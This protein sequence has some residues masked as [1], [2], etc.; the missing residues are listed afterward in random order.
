MLFL[1]YEQSE[2]DNFAS[3]LTRTRHVHKLSP[4]TIKTATAM[5]A[6]LALNVVFVA[7]SAD[8]SKPCLMGETISNEYSIQL[9]F[10]PHLSLFLLDLS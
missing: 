10:M 3:I 5:L 6:S 9:A 7:E 8:V 1:D 2:K 4:S